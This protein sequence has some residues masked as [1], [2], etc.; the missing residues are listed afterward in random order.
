MYQICISGAA[1]GR[2]AQEGEI[3]ARSAGAAIAKAN[4]TLLTGA[5]IG[6]PNYGAEAYKEADGKMS[7]G[8]SPAASK[9]EHVVKYRLPTVA[10]DTILYTGLHYIGRD[11]LLINSSDAVVSIGGRLGTLH[12]FT[13]AME[14][15]TPIGFLQGAGGVSNEIMEILDAAGESRSDNVVF[16]ED[17]E[18]LVKQLT[19]LL[20][21]RRK[22]YK[23]LYI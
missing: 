6:I 19:D 15:D 18:D 23:A 1:K 4:H 2:S 7:L 12:E 9:V 8:I 16:S 3:L 17:P 10:Y 21:E 13:I 14:T 20:D 11:V 5:T 22:K